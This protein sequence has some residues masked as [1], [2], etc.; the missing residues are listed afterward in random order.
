MNIGTFIIVVSAVWILSEILLARLK[1]SD[2]RSAGLDR[3]SLRLL[4]ITIILSICAAIILAMNRLGSILTG[5]YYIALTGLILILL[6]L[7]VRWTAILTLR[8]Y[9]TVDVTILKGH[10]IIDTGIYRFIRHP[11]Y[12]GSLISFLGLGL[13]MSN[14]LAVLVI[15]LPI[16]AAF[17]Y[18]IR[19]EEKSLLA[20]FGDR[21][22][23]YCLSAKRLIPYI[24]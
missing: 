8:K 21:Y 14:W 18:R 23:L 6:G 13:A 24:Y 3:K 15:F 2:A 5:S 12:T 20:F 16:L 22:M 17:I 1:H 7:T 19:I 11:S 10:Q 9:F 4:W